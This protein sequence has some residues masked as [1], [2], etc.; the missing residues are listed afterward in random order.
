MVIG[1]GH[2]RSD[3]RRPTADEAELGDVVALHGSEGIHAADVHRLKLKNDKKKKK[4]RGN[5]ELSDKYMLD[6]SNFI[7]RHMDV[8]YQIFLKQQIIIIFEVG[9][10]LEH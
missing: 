3:V 4:L 5:T 8:K 2:R 9:S 10:Y 7:G 1:V 6:A